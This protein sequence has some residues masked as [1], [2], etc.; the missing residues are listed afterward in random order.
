MNHRPRLVVNIR[1]DF[2]KKV[3]DA[4]DRFFVAGNGRGGDDDGIAL[5]DGDGLVQTACDSGKRRQGFALRASA[6]DDDLLGWNTL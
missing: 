5:L 4:R 1:A 2:R 3:H 6:H